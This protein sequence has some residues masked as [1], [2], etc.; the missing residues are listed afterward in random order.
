M[1]AVRWRGAL[2]VAASLLVLALAAWMLWRQLRGIEAAQL[3]AALAGLPATAIAAS[4]ACTA[5]SFACLAAYERLATQWLAPGRVPPA[6]AWRVGLESHALANT[7]G[8]HALSALAL[9]LRTYRAHGIDA[10]TLA[11]IVAAIGACVAVGVVAIA[12]SALA[13]SQ[14]LAGRGAM[15][16]V[17]VAF[18]AVALGVLRLRL[19]QMSLRSPVLAHAGLLLALGWL[20]MAAA[21]AAFAVLL[22]AGAMPDGPLLV[23]LFVGALLLGIVSHAPGGLGVFEATLLAAA[24]PTRRAEVLAALLAY[25]AIYNLLPCALALLSVGVGWARGRDPRASSTVDSGA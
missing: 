24:A 2:Q 6:V 23:L 1:N 5:V 18:A 11:R 3:R 13:W 19:R 20:E 8:L 15:V 14:W 22:P 7:L 17:V 21:I 16:L 12:L 10:A 9:R 4:L 25:R